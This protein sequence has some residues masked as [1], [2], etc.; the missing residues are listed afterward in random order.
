[1]LRCGK[2]T[3]HSF[4][5]VASVDTDY[6][7][8]ALRT[9]ID[10]KKLPGNLRSFARY[11]RD[12]HGGVLCVGRHKGKFYNQVFSDEGY[13]DWVASLKDPGPGMKSFAKYVVEQRGAARPSTTTETPP[14]KRRREEVASPTCTIC[15]SESIDCVFIPCGHLT[16]CLRC[17]RLVDSDD[18][19][20][21]ICR[22]SI[23]MIQKIFVA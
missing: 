8:W 7:A 16:C 15:Y 10:V 2:Y 9:S 11:L 6:C 20:C 4:E 3:G 21:P 22:Q 12:N 13:C 14:P 17:A 23:G 1:M 5:H 19:R 18:N